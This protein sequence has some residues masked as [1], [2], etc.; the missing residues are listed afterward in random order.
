[1]NA[2]VCGVLAA[3]GVHLLWTAGRSTTRLRPSRSLRS[4]GLPAASGV[5]GAL[6]GIAVLGGVAA[7]AVGVLSAACA[8]LG[9]RSLHSA[10]RDQSRRT[11]PVLLEE[12]RVLSESGGRSIPR[13]LFEAGTRVPEPMA[14][15]FRTAHRTW[16]VSADLDRT[17][18]V[19]KAELG[20]A[21]TDVVCETLL[22]AHEVGGGGL[23]RRL[24]RLAEDRR[25]DLAT[26]DVASAKL[27]GARFARRFVLVVPVGMAVAGQAVGTGRS[28]FASSGG[29]AVGFAAAVMVGACWLWAGHLLQL[30]DEPRVFP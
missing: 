12:I 25:R 26:R 28:A 20:D 21:S 10:R 7:L 14:G 24:A 13:A 2:L 5:V 23:G 1:M 19:L 3:A 6:V 27:A 4:L 18:A 30:P 17:L 22:V 16:R 29:Q 11:W 8:G 9:R 15:A